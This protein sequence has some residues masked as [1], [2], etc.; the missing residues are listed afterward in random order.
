MSILKVKLLS[1]EVYVTVRLCGSAEFS[2]T[3]VCYRKE[4]GTAFYVI[5][6]RKFVA[7]VFIQVTLMPFA[8]LNLECYLF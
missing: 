6:T 1:I 8:H 7:C 5:E 2:A 3:G 4:Q